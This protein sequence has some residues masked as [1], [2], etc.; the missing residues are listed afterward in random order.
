MFEWL[1]VKKYLDGSLIKNSSEVTNDGFPVIFS[2]N[3]GN[4]YTFSIESFVGS[5]FLK[6]GLSKLNEIKIQTWNEIEKN[7]VLNNHE[8]FNI[9]C[10]DDQIPVCI[11]DYPLGGFIDIYAALTNKE[12]L[13]V[14]E[15]YG[16]S[17]D[18]L[19][20]LFVKFYFRSLKSR[21]LSKKGL[22]FKEFRMD[23]TY[24]MSKAMKYVLIYSIFNLLNFHIYWIL[25]GFYFLTALLSEFFDDELRDIVSEFR[26][27]STH[28]SVNNCFVVSVKSKKC[29]DSLFTDSVK[30][31]VSNSEE[32][33]HCEIERIKDLPDVTID[34]LITAVKKVRLS[35]FGRKTEIRSFDLLE[36][37]IFPNVTLLEDRLIWCNKSFQIEDH[38]NIYLPINSD[39]IKRQAFGRMIEGGWRAPLINPVMNVGNL[40]EPAWE[41]FA[42]EIKLPLN[43]S[44]LNKKAA[45]I[46]EARKRMKL[47][48]FGCRHFNKNRYKQLINEWLVY[49][50]DYLDSAIEDQKKVKR[51]NSP[52]II[53]LFIGC[54]DYPMDNKNKRKISNLKFKRKNNTV[55]DYL[56]TKIEIPKTVPLDLHVLRDDKQN[57]FKF[58]NTSPIKYIKSNNENKVNDWKEVSRRKTLYVNPN[59]TISTKNYYSSLLNTKSFNIDKY[60]LWGKSETQGAVDSRKKT[61]MMHEI[62]AEWVVSV[63]PMNDELAK[64]DENTKVGPNFV[65][66][67][68][69]TNSLKLLKG[70]EVKK[71]KVKYIKLRDKK[72]KGAEEI[73]EE[74]EKQDKIFIPSGAIPKKYSFIEGVSLIDTYASTLSLMSGASCN[75]TIPAIYHSLCRIKR[76]SYGVKLRKEIIKTLYC[77]K[78]L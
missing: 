20:L 16:F 33:L 14:Y 37:W 67:K 56:Q 18:D 70:E 24:I 22:K 71:A 57:I 73:K 23:F 6:L 21:S 72:K 29:F 54:Y 75:K 11:G 4:D 64:L 32:G 9:P 27:V 17:I 51:G 41:R 8:D 58:Y 38:H 40:I 34:E 66:N 12:I 10:V 39:Q 31:N 3:L 68:S 65:T 28:L 49:F 19:R 5:K 63:A 47:Q 15:E 62:I 60:K 59:S 13:S 1:S 78:D 2:H 43:S 42:V 30:L 44:S 53:D 55:N 25:L 50:R 76:N 61:I 7:F 36:N 45:C 74:K 52:G 48:R 69:L 35:C 77:K 46:T 26:S